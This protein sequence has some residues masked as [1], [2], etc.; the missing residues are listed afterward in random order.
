MAE[1]SRSA[2]P[3]ASP[4]S[5]VSEASG[6]VATRA[7][8]HTVAAHVLARRRF[9]VSG[10][11][12]LRAGPA[13]IA[14][15]SFGEAPETIRISGP[16]LVREVGGS[17]TRMPINGSTL[18]DLAAFVDADVDAPFSGGADTP[19]PSDVDTPCELG[20]EDVKVIADW[21]ALGGRVLDE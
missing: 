2:V 4:A 10:R 1:S 21:F 13:G 18:R 17:S 15:P 19:P 7:A 9:D 3:T 6:A 5:T 12:G 20:Q 8:L 11:F 16:A 14:T